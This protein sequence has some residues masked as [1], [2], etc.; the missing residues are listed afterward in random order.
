LVLNVV[1]IKKSLACL[2]V[3]KLV[4]SHGGLGPGFAFNGFQKLLE[5][6]NIHHFEI[7][8]IHRNGAFA[9]KVTLTKQSKSSQSQRKP[10]DQEEEPS[11]SKRKR[12]HQR[13]GIKQELENPEK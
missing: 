1:L 12:T 3:V 9:G 4:K 10:V 7:N 6:Q 13:P 8:R 11:K 2:N 5:N